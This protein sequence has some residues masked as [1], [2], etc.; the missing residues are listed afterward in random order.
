MSRF[1]DLRLELSHVTPPV[2]RVLRVPADLRLDDLHHAIQA[3]MGWEDF[4][5]HLF[6]VGEHEYAPRPEVDVNDDDD[7]SLE[8]DGAW[9]GEDHE[10]T[11][12][13]A[14][15]QSVSGFTYIY[16]FAEDW[17]VRVTVDAES[18]HDAVSSVACLAGEHAGPQQESRDLQPFT[19]E[20]ANGR[21]TRSLRARA[22]PQFPAGPRASS[23]QQLLANLSLVV[24]MLGSR[25]TRHGTREAW[26]NIRTEMLDAL[27]EAGLIDSDSQRKSV[28]ITDAGVAHAQRLLQ[29]LRSL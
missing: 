10:V 9:A 21:L 14:L 26:K 15:K 2:W 3:V 6:E 5:P 22:T 7:D 12:A 20:A 18:E 28:T 29:K 25:A 19:V 8:D 16:D 11:V 1:F 4:H 23:D 17:R 27:T 13:Q 24:L